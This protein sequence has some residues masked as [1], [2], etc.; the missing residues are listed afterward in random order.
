MLDLT[1]LSDNELHALYVD[2]E[3]KRLDAQNGQQAIVKEQSRRHATERAKT[4]LAGMS[5][6]E[7]AA[8]VQELQAE[9]VI[10]AETIG[11]PG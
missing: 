3:A 5:A 2:F 10:S 6:A 4:K 9:G 11:E 8:L 1:K 7:K